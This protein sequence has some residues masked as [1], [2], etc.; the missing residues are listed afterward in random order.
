MSDIIK[1]HKKY[2]N[3]TK[4]GHYLKN[5]KCLEIVFLIPLSSTQPSRRKYPSTPLA[6]TVCAIKFT[7]SI[8]ALL[9][10]CVTFSSK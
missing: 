4:G 10:G 2:I 6:L 8:T 1:E 9:Y 7:Q 3:H 5:I